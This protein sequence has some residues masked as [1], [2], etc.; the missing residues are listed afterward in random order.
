MSL[1]TR[2]SYNYKGEYKG[3][4]SVRQIFGLKRLK[5]KTSVDTLEFI[6]HPDK[7]HIHG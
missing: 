3:Q 5:G 2:A 6:V 4:S 1:T 7:A